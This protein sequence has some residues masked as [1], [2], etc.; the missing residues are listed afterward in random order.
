[1]AVRLVESDAVQPCH[2]G[3][4]LRAAQAAIVAI[5]VLKAE[6]KAAAAVKAEVIRQEGIDRLKNKVEKLV[7][8][9]GNSACEHLNYQKWPEQ[10]SAPY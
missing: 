3:E 6:R 4:S 5:K 7:N 10:R 9:Y 2:G 8:K 1:M